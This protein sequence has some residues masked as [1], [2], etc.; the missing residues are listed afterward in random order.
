MNDIALS[1]SWTP[2]G[3]DVPAGSDSP[4]NPG[5]NVFTATFDGGDYTISGLR[6]SRSNSTMVGLFGAIGSRAEITSVCLADVNV[7][8]RELVGAL[9]GYVQPGGLVERS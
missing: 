1:G 7:R 4:H 6:V 8:G 3:G 2:I 9:V 5:A